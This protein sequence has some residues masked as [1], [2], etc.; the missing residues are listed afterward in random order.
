[1]R[2]LSIDVGAL[3]RGDARAT[4]RADVVDRSV[5]GPVDLAARSAF[6]PGSKRGLVFGAGPLSAA[7][8]PGSNRLVFAGRSPA[9]N[10]FYVSTIGSAAQALRG[11]GLDAVVLSGRAERT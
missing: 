3:E 6:R 4:E 10:G 1:M 9:W 2:V 11:V 8:I 5:I 7:E